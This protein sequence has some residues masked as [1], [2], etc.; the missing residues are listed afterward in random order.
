MTYRELLN[1]LLKASPAQL[2]NEIFVY[3][4]GRYLRTTGSWIE[5]EKDSIA[6]DSS[7]EVEDA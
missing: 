2:D 5:A 3:Y 4:E 7:L 6:T 1:L